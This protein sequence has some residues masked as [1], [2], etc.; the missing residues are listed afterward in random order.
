MFATGTPGLAGQD[1]SFPDDQTG[2]TW[3]DP[4]YP[5][6]LDEFSVM[7][8]FEFSPFFDRSSN[9]ARARMEGKDPSIP[10]VLEWVQHAHACQTNG[11]NACSL[12][13]FGF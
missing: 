3:H 8:Y 9:N 4:H 5:Y 11:S 12:P 1:Q 13:G 2:I 7:H 6:P 10:G